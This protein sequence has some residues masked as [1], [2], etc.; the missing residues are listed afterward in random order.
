MFFNPILFFPDWNWRNLKECHN[1]YQNAY[2]NIKI[3][4]QFL[5]MAH[6]C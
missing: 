4:S 3:A 1:I 2:L 5:N 6:Y